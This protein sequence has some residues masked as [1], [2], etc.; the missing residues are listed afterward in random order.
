[1][2][3]HQA[4][5][6]LT[7]RAVGVSKSRTLLVRA[8]QSATSLAMVALA[9]ACSFVCGGCGGD[10]AQV[11]EGK[12]VGEQ[13]RD[14]LSSGGEGPLMV[15]VPAG[16]FAMGSPSDEEGRF[17]DQGPLRGVL[18]GAPFAVGVYEVT[19][20]EW[21]ACVSG[22]GCGHA[23]H[24][25]RW[26]R[27][28]RPVI[29]VSWKDAQEYVKW[30]SVQTGAQYRLPTEA[31][32]EYVARAG[33][34]TPF[35]TGETTSTDQANYDGNHA[36]GDGRKGVY[37]K[38]TTPVGTFGEN[39]WALRD[40][41]GNVWEW[42]E[43]C[44]ND[45]YMGTPVDGGAWETGDCEWRVARGGSWINKPR[46]LR[47]ASRFRYTAGRR[48]DIL[49]FRV[50]RTLEEREVSTRANRTPQWPIEVVD[51]GVGGSATLLTLPETIASRLRESRYEIPREQSDVLT[52]FFRGATAE[53]VEPFLD[54]PQLLLQAARHADSS[55]IISL[56]IARGFDPNAQHGPGSHRDPWRVE[57]RHQAG[58]LHH[59]AKCNANPSVVEALV[60]GG[61]D[62]HAVG[63]RQLQPPLHIAARYNN[64]DVVLAL[65][66]SGAKPNA[67]GS[68]E[69]RSPE[70]NGNQAL[71]EAACN[72]DAS[73]IDALVGAGANVAS[74]NSG[75]FTP[76]HFAVL[77]EQAQSVS[78]LLSH[79]AD[80]GAVIV[81]V[82]DEESLWHD[83]I[84]CD[85]ARLLV[86]ALIDGRPDE[87]EI[88][89]RKF[90]EVLTVLAKAG[91]N[92]DSENTAGMYEG[93]SP[94]RLAMEAEL[95]PAVVAV[96]LESG[97]QAKPA[98]LH[99]LFAETF[100]YT[101]KYAGGLDFR[102]VG[103][104]DNLRV[105]DLLLS[106]KIDV[107]A[108]DKCGRTPLHRAASL[109]HGAYGETVG[110]VEKLLAAGAHVNTRLDH[111]G[112]WDGPDYETC[113]E[114][115]FTPLHAAAQHDESGYAIASMLLAAGADASVPDPQGK[116]AR[117]VAKS[118]RMK[119]L[120][121]AE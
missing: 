74:R 64:A 45:N 94:L 116:T 26:G 97:A 72:E 98:L 81:R 42:T 65:I 11:R 39:P 114:A 86:N 50:A 84:G 43:D 14:K 15:V 4:A 96:L 44:W 101:G 6:C 95:G 89:L 47:S 82:E 37:R 78:A 62:V 111:H 99:A 121:A 87:G 23:P 79:G 115:A 69:I 106:K 61:A 75:G 7:I 3:T 13:F 113:F 36:Y 35:H 34:T 68:G 1:M 93:F 21:D 71:H 103:S 41:H 25:S 59:A 108:K 31:E 46:L 77:C 29:N 33:T 67:V 66:R 9:V 120:L 40:V 100:Q 91:A 8:R 118:D 10:K 105:L 107:N 48:N 2:S 58:P 38:R 102:D 92:L 88:D 90:K 18:I 56:L 12:E 110:L 19:F 109:A 49:G 32:W 28:G 63:G 119:E 22:A 20:A 83:C 117:D 52:T 27:D 16:S 80:V 55:E 24:D 112:G 73:V 5:E 17:D 53:S 30:L 57:P 70:V 51:E 85:A 60:Q 104:A 54:Y 76:L